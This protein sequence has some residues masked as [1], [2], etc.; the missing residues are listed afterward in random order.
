LQ[1]I[2]K[3]PKPKRKPKPKTQILKKLKTQ[4]R[5]K[6]LGFLGAN[7]WTSPV[8]MHLLKRELNMHKLRPEK[9]DQA[10]GPELQVTHQLNH[11]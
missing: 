8:T 3:I 10:I 6:P 1:K 9:S 5:H 4:P 7:A 2:R 11:L